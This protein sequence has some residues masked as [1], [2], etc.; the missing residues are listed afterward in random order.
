MN[1][2]RLLA[3]FVTVFTV[4]LIVSIVVTSIS[5]LIVHGA[6]TIDREVSIRSALLFGIVLSWVGPRRRRNSGVV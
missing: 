1:I 5:N 2:K 6:I 4:T 3:D